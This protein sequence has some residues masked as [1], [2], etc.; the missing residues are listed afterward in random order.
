MGAG[1]EMT[2]KQKR[3]GVCEARKFDGGSVGIFVCSVYSKFTY[4]AV[5]GSIK[6]GDKNGEMTRPWCGGGAVSSHVVG[7]LLQMQSFANV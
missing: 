2:C 5:A 6:E 7:R 4:Y 1:D 3:E